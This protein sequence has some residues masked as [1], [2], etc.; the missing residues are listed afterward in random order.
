MIRGIHYFSTELKTNLM[1]SQGAALIKYWSV[2]K[3][4]PVGP[5]FPSEIL[6][7]PKRRGVRP[8]PSN[9]PWLRPCY[10]NH[11]FYC[12][13]FLLRHLTFTFNLFFLYLFMKNIVVIAIYNKNDIFYYRGLHI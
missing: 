8:N 12:F 10:I 7:C 5:T 1:S 2:F 6:V 13:M 3:L 11:L 4:S 9:P